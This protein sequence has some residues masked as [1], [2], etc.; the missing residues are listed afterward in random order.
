MAIGKAAGITGG[1]KG[2]PNESTRKTPEAQTGA[3]GIPNNTVPSVSGGWKSSSSAAVTGGW[4]PSSASN[5]PGRF[6]EANWKAL[7]RL[8]PDAN[9]PVMPSQS[10]W[11]AGEARARGK[12]VGSLTQQ[13]L[14]AIANQKG[15][16]GPS[17]LQRIQ[18]ST[19]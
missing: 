6:S 5:V 16:P 9:K 14:F 10:E 17:E 19:L 13:D 4:K 12:E 8:K 2:I 7:D 1:M 11:L 3:T 18:A 15:S